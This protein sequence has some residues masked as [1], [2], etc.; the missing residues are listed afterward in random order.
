MADVRS[1]MARQGSDINSFRRELG[2]LRDLVQTLTPIGK[3]TAVLREQ[4]ETV[5]AQVTR[6]ETKFDKRWDKLESAQHDARKDSRSLRNIL[7]GVGFAAVLSP[8]GGILVAV[9]VNKP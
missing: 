5:E 9:V 6:V 7:I 8:I 2:S 3:D 4:V 1:E